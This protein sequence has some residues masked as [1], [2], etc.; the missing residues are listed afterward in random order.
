[1]EDLDIQ[2]MGKIMQYAA[3]IKILK[4]E[5]KSNKNLQRKHGLKTSTKFYLEKE[6]TYY[7]T[8]RTLSNS[9]KLMPSTLE[10]ASLYRQT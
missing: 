3:E 6:R 8:L 10:K 7:Y 4:I 5:M 9:S 2:S 1:M